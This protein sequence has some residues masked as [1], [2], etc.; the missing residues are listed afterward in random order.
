[1]TAT[2]LYLPISLQKGDVCRT[3]A[4][5]SRYLGAVLRMKEGSHVI[6][7]NGAGTEYETVI[8]RYA[9]DGVELEIL[10]KRELPVANISLTLCQA[11][12]KAEKMDGI[13]RHATELGINRIIPFLSARSIPRPDSSPS[14]RRAKIENHNEKTSVHKLE[15]WRKIAI[16]ACR[17]SGRSDI[18]EVTD[19]MAFNDMLSYISRDGLRLIPWEE[20]TNLSLRDIFRQ[21]SLPSSSQ[22]SVTRNDEKTETK[23]ITLAIGPEGGFSTEEIEAARCAGFISVS[24]GKRV[25]RVET[26]SLAALAVIQYELN[27]D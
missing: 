7:F 24:L 19:I 3:T 14:S 9:G 15:R 18:P 26:A 8:K 11:I 25:L 17:Q 6:V 5:Q 20:E 12:P 2:R 22:N 27:Q 21:Q 4:D 10:E 23:T 16:E 1:M 13:I